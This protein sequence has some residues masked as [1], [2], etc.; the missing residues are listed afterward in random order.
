MPQ[1]KKSGYS[2]SFIESTSTS[3]GIES[4]KAFLITP[5]VRPSMYELRPRATLAAPKEEQILHQ[6]QI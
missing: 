1:A 3:I 2:A 5:S 6:L 4:L